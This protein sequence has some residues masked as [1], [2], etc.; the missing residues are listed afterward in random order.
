MLILK[1]FY[2]V[3]NI[4]VVYVPI[5]RNTNELILRRVTAQYHHDQ[6]TDIDSYMC[7]L[8]EFFDDIAVTITNM[9]NLA[10]RFFMIIQKALNVV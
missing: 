9:T 4:H 1:T 5:I 8:M 10:G 7:W 6:C 3:V 2:G